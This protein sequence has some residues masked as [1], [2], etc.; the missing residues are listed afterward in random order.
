[1]GISQSSG[2]EKLFYAPPPPPWID[3]VKKALPKCVNSL[4]LP[5]G[6]GGWGFN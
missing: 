4:A 2:A 3:G 6:L 5:R 1:M